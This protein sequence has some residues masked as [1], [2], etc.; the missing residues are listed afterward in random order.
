M[1]D[2]NIKTVREEE[3]KTGDCMRMIWCG[4][5]VIKRFE[6]YHGPFDFVARIAVFVD[7]SRMSLEKG[8]SY[9]IHDI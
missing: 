4:D 2:F 6:Q 8:H 3:L 5:K 9:K 7:G 1:L